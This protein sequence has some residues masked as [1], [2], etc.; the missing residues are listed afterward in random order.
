MYDTT[1]KAEN[2]IITAEDL[3]DIF[4]LMGEKLR[5]YLRTYEREKQ[6]NSMLDYQYQNFTFKDIGSYMKVNIDFYDN[7]SITFDNYDSFI[8]IY[9]NRLEEIKRMYVTYYLSYEVVTPYPN[10]TSTYYSNRIYMTITENKLDIDLNLNSADNKVNDIYEMIKN[11]VLN[12]PSKYDN[13]IKNKSKISTSVTLGAGLIPAIIIS[14]LLLL[15]PTLNTIFFKGFVIYPICVFFITFVIGGMISSSKLDDLY[16]QIIPDKKYAGYDADKHRSV[17]KDDIDSFVNSSE[18]LIGKKIYNL[19]KRNKIQKIYD[20][21]K[22]RIPKEL[23]MVLIISV[24][25]II[26]GLFI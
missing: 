6:M 24:I 26:I 14:T 1:I 17:Y 22:K 25:V 10:K 20:N 9:H 15:V 2:K 16:D 23:L 4:Q 19:D 8:G 3:A 21:Y 18:I 5:S 11:K 7:T 13:I 12:A